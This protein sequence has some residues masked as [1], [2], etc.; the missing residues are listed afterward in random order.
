[1]IIMMRFNNDKNNYNWNITDDYD[2]N[3]KNH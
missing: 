3:K 1:M 2:N